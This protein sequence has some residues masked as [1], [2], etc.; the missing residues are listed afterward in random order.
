MSSNAKKLAEII[1][2][3]KRMVV[4][5]GAGVSTES[6]IS[7]F[8]SKGGVFEQ[9]EKK[10]RMSPEEMLSIDFFERDPRLF[11]EIYR[12]TF[13]GSNPEPND[14]HK[15]FARLEEMGIVKAVV[16]Q[17]IDDLH[18]RGGSKKVLELHGNMFRNV[19]SS[20]RKGFSLD[21]VADP[22]N[23]VPKC[24]A[25]GDI[26]RPDVVLYGEALDSDVIQESVRFISEADTLLVA[27]TSLRVY[28]A[29]G[30]INYFEGKD[31]VLVNRDSTPFDGMATLVI[32]ESIGSLMKQVME[33]IAK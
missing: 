21:Y 4:F 16:T 8:R 31:L 11:Y 29:A 12:A 19:C 25:C 10:Y 17:N 33:E 13:L 2:G 3:S 7:D 15:A 9:I 28:P 6:G 14:C 22:K 1:R 18:Q 26:V 5:T 27:G 24:D 32:R 20:C 30:F 23:P